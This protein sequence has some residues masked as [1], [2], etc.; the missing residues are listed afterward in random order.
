MAHGAPVPLLLVG[1]SVT[2]YGTEAP[3]PVTGPSPQG[4]RPWRE[5]ARRDR[6]VNA[7]I[8]R[9]R[10]AARIQAR[11]AEREAAA[12]VRQAAADGRRAVRAQARAGRA[13]RRAALAAWAAG[14]VMDLLFVPVIAVPA[15]LA[16]TAMAAYGASL[17]GPAGRALPAFSEGA[18]WVFA[19]A[20]TIARRHHPGR[21]VWHLRLGV[22]VFAG[23]GAALNFAHGLTLPRAGGPVAGVVM[24]LVSV[25]GV[26]AHQLVTAGP[27]RSRADREAARTARA[28]GRRERAARMAAIRRAVVDLGEEGTARLVFEPGA[29]APGRRFALLRGRTRPGVT[30]TGRPPAP[31]SDADTAPDDAD[32]PP[33]DGPDSEP[34]TERTPARTRRPAPMAARVAA[35]RT[36]HPDMPAAD[37]AKRLGISDRTVRRHLSGPGPELATSR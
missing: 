9:D 12:R 7:Q 33:T 20:V 24:A 4:A 10:E 14:H 3:A 19:A 26:T 22:I 28:I 11:I 37:I 18:M 32:T 35:I 25:A 13:A 27:R 31:D 17:Y 21:P 1:D 36:R 34:D 15:M 2:A 6:L 5:E 30:A 16:W 8:D 29:A 23:F